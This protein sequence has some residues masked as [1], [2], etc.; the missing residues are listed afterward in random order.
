M[1]PQGDQQQQYQPPVGVGPRVKNESVR[2]IAVRRGGIDP[3][4]FGYDPNIQRLATMLVNYQIQPSA[5]AL[6]KPQW[7]AAAAAAQALD[8][9]FDASQ[10]GI[11][12]GVRKAFTSGPDAA[13]LTAIDTTMKHLNSLHDA[14]GDL[15]NTPIQP[16]NWLVNNAEQALMDYKMPTR[17]N[18]RSKAVADEL[19]RVFRGT[20]GSEKDV[21]TWLANMSPNLGPDN[22]KE[23]VNSAMELLAG[24]IEAMRNKWERG[25]QA[26]ADFTFFTDNAKKAIA[27]LGYDPNALDQGKLVKLSD[28]PKPQESAAPAIPVQPSG[29]AQQQQNGLSNLSDEEILKRLLSGKQ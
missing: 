28:Q 22:Q 8:P 1:G 25:F 16:L 20:G 29:Q 24:R 6:S 23:A 10:Y 5:F 4:F 12:F 26:P 15:H 19:T 17:Y 11:R 27:K 2:D 7:M 9:N 14:I 18:M 21:Q 3:Q 13:N